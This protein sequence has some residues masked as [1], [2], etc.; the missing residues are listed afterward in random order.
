MSNLTV[1]ELS[2]FQ[3]FIEVRLRDPAANQTP[4]ELLEEW[5][6][7]RGDIAGNER[8]RLAVQAAIRDMQN[9]DLGVDFDS[10]LR[11]LKRRILS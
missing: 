5:R 4:E 3:Q 11:D 7:L 2:E 10:H 9:G 1:S 6:L 8:D